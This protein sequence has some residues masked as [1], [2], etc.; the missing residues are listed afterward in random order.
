MQASRHSSNKGFGWIDIARLGL[1]QACIGAVVVLATSTLNRVMVV[2]LGLAAVLPGA[3]VAMHYVVQVLR[4]RM[5]FGADQTGRCTPWIVGG[6]AILASGG[7]LASLGTSI[8][9]ESPSMG[10]AVVTLGFA[11]IGVGVSAC[12]TSVLTLLAKRTNERR[13]A[14]AATL[15]WMMMIAG[16]AITAGVAGALLD[17]FSPERL[18]AVAGGV[19]L[20]AFILTAVV[21]FGLESRSGPLPVATPDAGV[22]LNQPSRFREALRSV[23]SEPSTRQFT[24][25]VGISML[26]FSTQDLILEPFAG[27]VFGYTPG[28]STQLSGTQHAGVLAGMILVALAGSGYVFGRRLGSLRFWT[29]SGCIAS[30]VALCGLSIGGQV[31]MGWPLAL[32]VFL[33]GLANGAFSI[34]AIASMMRLA[35]EGQARREG[36][37]MGLWGAAQALAFGLGGLLG[38]SLSDI[39]RFFMDS[40]GAA[41]GMVFAFEALLFLVAAQLGRGIAEPQAIAPNELPDDAQCQDLSLAPPSQRA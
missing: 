30:A 29:V 15:V 9:G 20:G 25:F 18:L 7:W 37:R 35:G 12:G 34:A 39:A 32:N 14:G 4:P 1:V 8:M 10:L 6:M 5:G 11:L 16:F 22:Y 24:W 17:P 26:A 41:Y 21:I 2:E 33:L 23:L 27:I 28:E 36:T 3:L 19:T 31:G 13:R 38:T 40:P